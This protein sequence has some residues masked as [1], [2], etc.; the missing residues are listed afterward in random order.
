M[1]YGHI[2]GAVYIS[3]EDSVPTSRTTDIAQYLKT[4]YRREVEHI[5]FSDNIFIDEVFTVVRAF[6]S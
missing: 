1:D 4:Q 6:H 2:A 3:T 5:N